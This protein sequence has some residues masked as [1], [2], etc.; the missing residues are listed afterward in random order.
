MWG[1]FMRHSLVLDLSLADPTRSAFKAELLD[2]SSNVGFFYLTGHGIVD[3]E[4]DRCWRLR[5][6]SSRNRPR[7]RTRSAS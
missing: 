5:A 4:F 7:S 3:D 6:A 2:A 1:W